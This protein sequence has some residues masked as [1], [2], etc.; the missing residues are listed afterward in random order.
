M[1]SN[2]STIR[3]IYNNYW[4]DDSPKNLRDYP[5]KQQA[6]IIGKF[7][8]KLKEANDELP[9]DNKMITIKFLTPCFSNEESE[10]LYS[11][12]MNDPSSSKIMPG[13]SYDDESTTYIYFTLYRAPLNISRNLS[14][15]ATY[16]LY[17]EN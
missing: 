2:A 1:G 10:K 3:E 8:H 6:K 5:L 11:H 7:I 16:N 14:R 4:D 17:N 15:Y 9:I 12:L 13:I